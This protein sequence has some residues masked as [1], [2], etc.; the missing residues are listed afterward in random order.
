MACVILIARAPFPSGPAAPERGGRFSFYPDSEHVSGRLFLFFP[1]P[2][3]HFSFFLLQPRHVSG[4]ASLTFFSIFGMRLRRF[5]PNFCN[6]AGSKRVFQCSAND[7]KARC[8]VPP[9][10][11]SSLPDPMTRSFSF[12]PLAQARAYASR[13]S[14]AFSASRRLVMN[15]FCSPKAWKLGLSV[16]PSGPNFSSRFLG[17]TPQPVPLS[18]FAQA[19]F[20]F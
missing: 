6:P 16:V 2:R 4:L 11:P 7:T 17:A 15:P 9:S 13:R 10:P 18:F 20:F 14:S 1:H 3:D 12:P 8:C 19:E 5:F